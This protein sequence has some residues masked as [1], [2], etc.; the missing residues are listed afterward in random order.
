MTV[1]TR[2]MRSDQQTVNGLTAYKLGLTKSGTAAT[3]TRAWTNTTDE[4]GYMAVDIVKRDSAGVETVLY[5]KAAQVTFGSPD[6]DVELSATVAVAQ[7]ALA[8]TDSI[9][10]KVYGR[11][12]GSTVWSLLAT[13]TTEQLGATQLSAATWTVYYTESCVYDYGSSSLTLYY[14]FDGA[15]NTRIANFTWTPAAAAPPRMV[16]DGLTWTVC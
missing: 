3:I 6:S 13:F 15:Y 8:A 14:K 7:T 5:S 4:G 10:V 16:G 2:Y 12:A 9:V 11:R 1:E